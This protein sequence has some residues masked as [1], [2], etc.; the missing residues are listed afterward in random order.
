[1]LF[2][3]AVV[4]ALLLGGRGE[5]MARRPAPHLWLESA[6]RP[7]QLD[8]TRKP[9][10]DLKSIKVVGATGLGL[11]LP[12]CDDFAIG[13]AVTT[14]RISPEHRA[15]QYVAAIRIRF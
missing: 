2:G 1:M 8:L 7:T 6:A 15:A 13:A 3:S 10:I 9:P 14:F 5:P 4:V 12:L 11:F